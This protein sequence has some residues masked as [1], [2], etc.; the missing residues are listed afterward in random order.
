MPLRIYLSFWNIASVVMLETGL[1]ICHN[2]DTQ[3][4][5]RC[6]N[7]Q[8]YL[9]ETRFEWRYETPMASSVLEGLIR[10]GCSL[11]TEQ[12]TW[13]KYYDEKRYILL[14]KSSH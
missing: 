13:L 4:Y 8:R 5:D 3:F 12:K 6:K 11:S 7:W 14:R 10:I 2:L 1:K 9:P